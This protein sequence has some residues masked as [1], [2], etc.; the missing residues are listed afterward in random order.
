VLAISIPWVAFEH[1]TYLF[2]IY[3]FIEKMPAS[4]LD[5]DTACPDTFHSLPQS[6][7]ENARIVP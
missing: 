3:Q 6:L 7:Q 1:V 2:V 5:E 4:N